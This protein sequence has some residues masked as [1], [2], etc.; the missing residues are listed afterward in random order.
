MGSDRVGGSPAEV[1][2]DQVAAEPVDPGRHGG[3]RGEHG[4]GPAQLD[5]L[6][7]AEALLGVLAD[8]LHAQEAG[9]PL[10]GVEDLRLGV[11]GEGTEGPDRAD[12]P[13]AQQQFL[14][15]PV[16]AAA[17][18]QPVGDLAQR[19]L[20]LFHVGV[21]Q[22]QRHPADLGH[23]DLRRQQLALGQR[24]ADPHG[25]PVAGAEQGERQ[26]VRVAGRVTLG[27]PA[28]GR[29]GLGEVPVPVQQ[30]HP[31][32][33]HPQVT[34]G[35]E[36]ITRQDAQAAR[37]LR[38]R[39]GDPVFRR[40]V[41]DR[42]GRAGRVPGGASAPPVRVQLVPPRPGEVLVQ[43]PGRVVEPPQEG[44]VVAEALELGRRHLAEQ[45]DRVMAG[46]L[47]ARRV[48]RREQIPGLG[49]PGPAEVQREVTQ[50]GKRLW[51]RGTDGKTAD[52]SHGQ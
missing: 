49:M 42:G 3:V 50:R 13:H 20:V 48:D 17:A 21:E 16:I 51:E 14:A 15:Q 36:M 30:A 22:E 31:D 25:G 35:L 33:R 44:L 2:L 34:A 1:P 52:G 47:P 37:V 11:P 8:A 26:P 39:L 41:G 9:V 43:V 40:E 7:E 46:R 10:V 27:L 12:S 45:G 28:L 18:V 5:G 19:R 24:H 6:L 32:E 29:Q 38:Q 4:G 23:P